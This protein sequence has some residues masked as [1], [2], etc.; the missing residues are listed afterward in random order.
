MSE[1][2]HRTRD[3]AVAVLIDGGEGVLEGVDVDAAD[4]AAVV[5]SLADLFAA[6]ETSGGDE[7]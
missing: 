7:S 2:P 5:H 6:R 1:R 4:R 3:G